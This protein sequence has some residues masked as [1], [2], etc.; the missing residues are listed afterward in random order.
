VYKSS[1]NGSGASLRCMRIEGTD[2]L[3]NAWPDWRNVTEGTQGLNYQ[4]SG[5]GDADGITFVWIGGGEPAGTAN[6]LYARRLLASNGLLGWN[7]TTKHICVANGNQDR[8]F[9]KKSGNN[10]FIT[11][12]DGRP[13]VVGNS[14]IYAQKFTINGIILWEE[15]GVQVANLN[16]YIPHPEFDLDQ[17]NTMCVAH[18][19]G[20]GF[21]AHK[22]ST[23][24][25]V[26]W[27]PAGVMVF[28]NTYSPF[29][30]DF[31]VIHSLNK[32]LVVGTDENKV[33]MNKVH[34]AVVQ[35][36]QTVTACNEFT[37][38][39]ETFDETG[40][41]TI[42]YDP[43][44]TLTLNLTIINNVAEFDVDGLTLTAVNDGAFQWYRCD[45]KSPIPGATGPIYTV[46]ESGSYTLQLTNGDCVDLGECI[47]VTIASIDEYSR[48][49]LITVYPNPAS[50]V[51]H[52][53]LSRLNEQPQ[54]I[55]LFNVFGQMIWQE[56][57]ISTQ[58]ISVPVEMLASGG[59]ILEITG[60]DFS[61]RKHWVKN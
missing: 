35:V 56:K 4:F 55:T 2:N 31:N 40:V 9:W 23:D 46:T 19:G 6:N 39:G 60:N 32:F 58:R 22:V 54:S 1:G 28:T 50:N 5:I 16:T 29:Y 3:S 25:T 59:Y 7:E 52:V 8:F 20:P 34:P 51:L 13:G 41:Y 26:T 15:N 24:G 36:E 37:I 33:F 21:T 11:W 27:G 53:D 18:R 43:D 47:E 48:S 10:Y 42:D 17:D 30:Q 12:A 38:Y 44:T 45:L 61:V 49:E 57:I 14:A